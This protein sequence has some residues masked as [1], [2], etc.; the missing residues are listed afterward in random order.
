[1]MFPIV[2]RATAAIPAGPKTLNAAVRAGPISLL[3]ASV[4]RSARGMRIPNSSPSSA[5]LSLAFSAPPSILLKVCSEMRCTGWSVGPSLPASALIRWN[6]RVAPESLTSMMICA[7]AAT[8]SVPYR[9]R[10]SRALA[11]VTG[12]VP[13]VFESH[14]APS[15]RRMRAIELG[16]SSRDGE[17]PPQFRHVQIEAE[18]NAHAEE[19][20]KL[21][22]IADASVV[23]FGQAAI[24]LAGL[25]NLAW[26][27]R[28]PRQPL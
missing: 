7:V 21:H 25:E 3:S 18:L 26:I 27:G 17:Q 19:R 14:A 13:L 16:A 4:P 15:A 5:A 11:I 10:R 8:G 12:F 6:A 28:R 20:F 2:V 9:P 22:E 1:M 23:P 24:A